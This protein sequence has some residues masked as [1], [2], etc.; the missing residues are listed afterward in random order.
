MSTAIT[1]TA[2]SYDYTFETDPDGATITIDGVRH[3]VPKPVWKLI[4]DLSIERDSL[5]DELTLKGPV[6][7]V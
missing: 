3:T 6:Y 7:E 1:H 4:L 5:A 2:C